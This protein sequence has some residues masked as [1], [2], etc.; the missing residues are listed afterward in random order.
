MTPALTVRCVDPTVGAIV[1]DWLG[2]L[3]L[4]PPVPLALD[5]RISANGTLPGADHA[6]PVLFRQPEVT[7]R[8][9]GGGGLR[10]EWET[11]PAWADLAP[12][13]SAATVYLSA[14][15][16]RRAED[17]TRTFLM[18]V[19][20]LL[21]RR[22]G[23]HHVHAASAIDASGTGWLIAGNARAG[24]STTAALLATAGWQVGSDDV[25]FLTA[26]PGGVGVVAARAPLALRD[27]GKRLLARAGGTALGARGK[28]GYFPEDLGGAWTPFVRPDIVLFTTVGPGPT[29][30][31]PLDARAAV[32][33]LVRWS[34]WVMLE[35]DLA[36]GHL[37][38]LTRLARQARCYRVKLGRDLFARPDRLA[39]LTS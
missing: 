19:L 24:K 26:R 39:E 8:R 5:L 17:A 21:V 27:G 29:T 12:G 23:W 35:P 38:L 7:I 11:A 2:A 9:G 37:D 14:A 28:T 34:A 3:R 30:A 18:G 36:Q 6:G 1:G 20:V 13:A 15:A 32:A 33:E 16:A 25:A 4:E 22:A 10:I 31:A